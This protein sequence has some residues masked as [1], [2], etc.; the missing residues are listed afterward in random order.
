MIPF[1]TF[2]TVSWKNIMHLPHKFSIITIISVLSFYMG[3]C[4]YM[5]NALKQA[6]Y[7]EQQKNSPTQR[8]YK[9]ML[10]TENFFVYGKIGNSN[11][12]N[13]DAVAVAA[14]STKQGHHGEIVDVSHFTGIDSYFGLNL[15]EGDYNLLIASDLNKDGF[16]DSTEIVGERPLSLNKNEI[17]EKVLGDYNIDITS[18]SQT[19]A[20]TF[21]LKVKKSE[22]AVESLFYPKG[23]IRTLD[24]EIFSP[25]MASLGMYEPAAFLEEAPMMFYALEEDLGYKVPVIFVHGI[26]GSAR[27]FQEI[28]SKLDRSRYRP[29][30]FY[31]PSGNDLSQLS[32]MFYK[33]FLSGKV[34]SLDEM[35]MVIVSHSMGG[36]VVRD[37]LNRCTGKSGENKV[38]CLITIASPLAGHSSADLANKGLIVLPSWRDVAPDSK[39]MHNLRRKKLPDGLNYHLIYAYGNTSTVK[40]GENSDGVVPLSSQLSIEAQNEATSQYG[41]N[42]THTGILKNPD[43]IQRILTITGE[44]KSLFPEDHMKEFLKGGYSVDLGD[45][46][47]PIIKYT[48]RTV[49]HW[50]DAMAT[51]VIAPIH[52]IQTHFV[53]VCRGEKSPNSDFEKAWLR[54][55]KQYP[56]R[57]A[58]K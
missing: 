13:R 14:V 42:D 49:G 25:G 22:A 36:L 29:W 52:P 41:F 21:H 33:I 8:I 38:K 10:V 46:Y 23:S 16:Y 55:I 27:D 34:V 3:G 57:N 54:F 11:K 17:P 40:F 30:F 51:G 2:I 48:I 15:P 47:P 50:V 6:H 43:A 53:Q 20:N 5:S 37:A 39:F 58:L 19:S 12:L 31:Y 28:V 35:P 18:S 44:I 9:H 32:E 4:T 7:S 26:G 45:E 1:K 24:D 56:D